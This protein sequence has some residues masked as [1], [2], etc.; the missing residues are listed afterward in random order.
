MRTRVLHA[1]LVD[2]ALACLGVDAEGSSL[3][4]RRVRSTVTRCRL[5]AVE[6]DRTET[7]HDDQTHCPTRPA[8]PRVRRVAG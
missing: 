1:S 6:S 2:M 3:S 8:S 7:N 4:D 5:L